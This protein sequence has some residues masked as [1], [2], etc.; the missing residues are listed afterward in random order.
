MSAGKNEISFPDTQ[1]TAG[2]HEIYLSAGSLSTQAELHVLPGWLT[3]VPPLLAIALA[4][5]TR[6]VLISLFLGVFGGAM[7]LNGW[8]PATAFARTIDHFLL[9]ALASSDHAAIVVFT[10]LLGGMVGLITKSGGTHG[11]VE[12]L[13]RFATNPRRGQLATW[14]MGV[15]IFFDDY[16][17]TLIVGPTM[18]PIT[19]KLRISREKLAYIVDSTAAPVVCLIPISTWVGFE[20][21]LISDA[22]SK[23]ALP[24]DA[25]TTF[26]YT[27]PY[28]FYPIFALVLGF[29]LAST[30]FD[31]GPMRRAEE[32]SRRTGN[33]L[34]EGA[35][36]IADYGSHHTEPDPSIP[37]RAIN[38]LAPI[39]MVVLVTVLGLYLTGSSGLERTAGTGLFD[40]WRE[41]LAN[42]NSF[43]A[44]LWASLSGML[45]ALLLPVA[46]RLVSLR[47]A[48][49]A[50]VEGF[51]SMLLA[52][53]VLIFA[54][55]IGAVCGELHT[56]HYLVGLA[57]GV[58][59][60]FWLPALTFVLAAAIAFATGTSWGTMAILTPLVIP[61]CHSLALGAGATADT[62]HY[63]VLMVSSI[64]SVLAGSVWGDHCS[65]ISDTTILSSMASGC[66][67]IAH[68]ATQLP[69]ALTIGL[70]A[71]AA[72]SIPAA[73]GIR[74]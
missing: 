17:N 30:G 73:L 53:M 63:F 25:Y 23:L 36:P 46:Q 50:M 42:A 12:R 74:P 8:N 41:V 26:L 3:I 58:I 61:I 14:L 70:L 68:V 27:I 9:D 48:M 60:P 54:W 6:D 56:A 65:P 32:R 21:G 16:A 35:K 49:G 18:R 34:G 37:K 69:Y 52:L 39:F 13:Q 5:L 22:F 19:D 4:L 66:D 55:A 71:L 47:D 7:I 11:I 64:A 31:F 29:T 15:F 51:R 10:T 33:P 67:H 20:I 43:K 2:K 44:L 28:R 40:W 1:L 45:T 57:Q 24:F 62:P 72:G 59:T 38:A